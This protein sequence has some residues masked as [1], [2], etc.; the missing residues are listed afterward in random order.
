[1]TLQSDSHFEEKLIFCLKNEISNLVKA[2]FELKIWRNCAVK[3]DLWF[4]KWHKEIGEFSYKY[5]KVMLDKSFVYNAF[6][7][8]KV[9]YR[10]ST[11]WTFHYLSELVQIPHVIVETRSQILYNLCTI[12]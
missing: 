9:A 11:F 4:Q 6:F 1:M 8:T 12:L 10:I 3:N 2:M 7:W 5:F